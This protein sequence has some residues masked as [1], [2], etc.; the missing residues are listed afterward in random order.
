MSVVNYLKESYEE[1]RYKVTWLS[2]KDAQKSAMVVAV[3][4]IIFALFVFTV[5][6]VFQNIITFYF[7]QI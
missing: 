2:F 4:T 7:Q 6:K 3:F 1:V 5:D